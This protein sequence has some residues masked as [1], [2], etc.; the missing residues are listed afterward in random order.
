[1]RTTIAIIAANLLLAS[2]M[3]GQSKKASVFIKDGNAAWAHVVHDRCPNLDIVLRSES[4]NYV[5]EVAIEPDTGQKADWAVYDS[6]GLL[7][8]SGHTF[9]WENSAKDGCDTVSKL[10]VNKQ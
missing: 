10:A 8:A 1:M 3:S 2:F 7:V 9:K 4:A 5:L 6:T